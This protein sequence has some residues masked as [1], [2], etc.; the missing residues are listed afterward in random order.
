M[1]PTRGLL[2]FLLP[3]VWVSGCAAS[4]PV[5][6]EGTIEYGSEGPSPGDSQDP[7]P[8]DSQ[9]AVQSGSPDQRGSK[10]GWEIVL[11]PYALFANIVG[12]AGVGRAGPAD[13]DVDFD[14]ILE[15]LELGAMGHA[16]V[17]V[18]RWG[19]LSD[20]AYMKLGDDISTPRGGVL[21][22]EVEQLELE[23]YLS[24]RFPLKWGWVDAYAGARY[25]NIGIDLKLTGPL[26]TISS[27]RREE[28]V[29]PVVGGRIL[30]DAT[31]CLSLGM[32][33]DIGGFGAASDFSWNVVA[34]VNWH[35]TDWFALTVGY[36]ALGV[37]YDN[38]ESGADSFSYDTITHGPLLGFLFIF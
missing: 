9:D 19:L 8:G 23:A 29:D 11:A 28:W 12:D 26:T 3:A 25:W 7:S 27:D 16:E 10:K 38:D 24:Y 4:S 5:L 35:V 36:R 30:F 18:G 37:D 22:A 2:L 17:R 32:R 31:E 14:D 6:E 34:T 33:A 1:K 21:D 13:V 15:A 20:V